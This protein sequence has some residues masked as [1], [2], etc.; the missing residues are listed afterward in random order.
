MFLVP[1]FPSVLGSEL[2]LLFL[3][4][5]SLVLVFGSCFVVTA[6]LLVHLSYLLF[7]MGF[8]LS[9]SLSNLFESSSLD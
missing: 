4:S 3:G 5:S 9:G 6:F 2:F 1:L 8:M 7:D